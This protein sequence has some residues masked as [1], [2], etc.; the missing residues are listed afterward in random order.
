MPR[1]YFDGEPIYGLLADEMHDPMASR[2]AYPEGVSG[3]GRFDPHGVTLKQF[4]RLPLE[5]RRQ[6]GEYWD[7]QEP[8]Y[9]ANLMNW[10]LGPREQPLL[11]MPIL[12]FGIPREG[13]NGYP[14]ADD[15][16][17]IKDATRYMRD[18]R[19][20]TGS[21]P[22]VS[23]LLD[24][25]QRETLPDFVRGDRGRLML[26]PDQ[27]RVDYMSDPMHYRLYMEEQAKMIDEELRRRSDIP[28]RTR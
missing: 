21:M 24:P 17:R 15:K 25:E 16:K 3:Y 1:H 14:W 22:P 28:I 12:P 5:S 18:Y 4:D 27:D 20:R 2:G 11:R 7:S 19:A 6:V 9:H 10:H 8:A 23:S 26:P 13:N